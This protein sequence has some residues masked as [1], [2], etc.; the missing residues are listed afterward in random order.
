MGTTKTVIVVQHH[1]EDLPHP[2]RPNCAPDFAAV[3]AVLP[4]LPVLPERLDSGRVYDRDL[5]ILV[6]AVTAVVD[7]LIR[8]DTARRRR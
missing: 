7:A 3:L 4:V 5:P 8:R 2:W 1:T 6:P